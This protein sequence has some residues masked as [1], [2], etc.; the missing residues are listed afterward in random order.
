MSNTEINMVAHY[1]MAVMLF[2]NSQQPSAVQNLTL[3][4]YENRKQITEDSKTHT[5]HKV[6]SCEHLHVKQCAEWETFLSELLSLVSANRTETGTEWKMEDLFSP[7]IK[8]TQ[9]CS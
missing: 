6:R 5:I 8:N 9:Q 4:E 2:T 3:T 1:M 7:R